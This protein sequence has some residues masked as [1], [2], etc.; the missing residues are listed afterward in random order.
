MGIEYVKYESPNCCFYGNMGV[1]V[2]L[3][4][5]VGNLDRCNI[6]LEKRCYMYCKEHIAPHTQILMTLVV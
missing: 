4:I 2:S 1:P 3:L 5:S 6:R